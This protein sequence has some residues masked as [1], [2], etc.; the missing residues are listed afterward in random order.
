MST[1]RLLIKIHWI[2]SSQVGVDPRR[3]VRALLAT[4]A[5][6]RDYA[7]FRRAYRGRAFLRPCLHDRFDEGG[8]TKDEYFWQ[9]LLVA[10]WIHQANPVHHV[11]VG[12][13]VDGFV[14][15]LAAFRTV[16]V[17]DVRRITSEIPGV[18]FSQRDMMDVSSVSSLT[19]SGAG[20]CDSISCLHALEHFGLGRYGDPIDPKGYEK[21]IANM[22]GLLRAGGV[23]YLSTP[24]GRE[25]VEF[26]ANWVFDPRTILRLAEA[27]GL[28]HESLTIVRSGLEVE[29]ASMD[30]TAME[31]LAL[32][33]YNL[34]IFTF[35]KGESQDGRQPR[36]VKKQNLG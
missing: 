10:R 6:V 4:P 20:Y 36:A 14:A 8:A 2:L 21:G 33:D 16:E 35:R 22:A 26:N 13:R 31:T 7:R 32:E 15:H 9:D 30:A 5:F 1:K 12:S 18:T 25:R 27:V 19:A 23:L 28:A 17:F 34:G 24:I 11:D 3:F 29:T